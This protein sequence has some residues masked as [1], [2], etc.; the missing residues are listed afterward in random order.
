M[1]IWNHKRPKVN[2]NVIIQS[3]EDEDGEAKARDIFRLNIY[4]LT[5]ESG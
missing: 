3:I 4:Y 5:K 1:F 2:T